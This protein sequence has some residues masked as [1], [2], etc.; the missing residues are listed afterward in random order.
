MPAPHV[1][2][3]L[4]TL[5]TQPDSVILSIGAVIFDPSKP[6]EKCIQEEFYVVVSTTSCIDHGLQ[7]SKDTLDWWDKQSKE[8][9][10]VI[11]IASDN[12]HPDCHTLSD[13][14]MKLTKF[15]P[16]N[17]RI[18]SNGANFDQPILDVAR[19]RCNLN[20]PW[21]Y[22]NSRCYRTVINL[23]PDNKSIAPK[24]VLAH[25]ALEDAKWQ[26]IHLV[27]VAAELGITLR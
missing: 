25:N 9:R 7:I 15:I 1:Q 21:K 24:K 12:K 27:N 13:A 23:H 8:A 20:L 26:S 5:G 19:T 4:E 17:A 3:D 11:E 10:T 6:P 16:E 18:W 14:L 22:F 2:I